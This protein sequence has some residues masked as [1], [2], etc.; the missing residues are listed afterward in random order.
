MCLTPA[1]AYKTSTYCVKSCTA[2][3]SRAAKSSNI[4]VDNM[5]QETTNGRNNDKFL[6]NNAEKIDSL[7]SYS[8]IMEEM[9][10]R[11]ML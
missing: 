5:A 8:C 4:V 2:T 10:T 6:E 3:T 7:V 11:N 9:E 1:E